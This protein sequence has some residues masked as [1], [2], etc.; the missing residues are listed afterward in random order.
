MSGSWIEYV[1]GTFKH[2]AQA[3]AAELGS[4]PNLCYSMTRI[5][6]HL[7]VTAPTFAEIFVH[8]RQQ[9]NNVPVYD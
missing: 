5:P 7:H 1:S 4:V 9:L 3:G 2:N 8:W 6:T